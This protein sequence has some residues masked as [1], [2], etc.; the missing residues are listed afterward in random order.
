MPLDEEWQKIVYC[1]NI[2]VENNIGY[3]IQ[4][5]RIVGI[6]SSD[7]EIC[8]ISDRNAIK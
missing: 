3:K 2:S 8:G 4:Y 7:G 5:D 6:F 1:I